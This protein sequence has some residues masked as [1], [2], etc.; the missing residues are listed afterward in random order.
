MQLPKA[1]IFDIQGHTLTDE[2]KRFYAKLN[3]LGFILFARNCESPA[4]L[5]KL[6]DDL[7]ALLERDDVLILID[8]EGGRVARLKPPHWRKAP[9]ASFFADIANHSIA[10]AKRLTYANGRRI[11]RELFELGINVDCA[12]LADVPVDG[13]HDVIGDRAY[14]D[15][16]HQVSIFAEAMARGLR[17]GGVLPVLKHIPGHGRAMVD[18]HMSLPVVDASLATL[19]ATDFIPF[20]ALKHLPLGMTAHVLYLL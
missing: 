6:V 17:D 10:D 16:A 7:K 19:R 5:K 3:P 8:Q 2:E 15:N 18:S 20:T 9:P 13:A 12:P 1:G 4:Q 14:G 11:A